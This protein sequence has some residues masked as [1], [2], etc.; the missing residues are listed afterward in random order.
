MLYVTRE[1]TNL[2]KSLF[3]VGLLLKYNFKINRLGHNVVDANW[4]I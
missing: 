3:L 4:M 1:N 2:S